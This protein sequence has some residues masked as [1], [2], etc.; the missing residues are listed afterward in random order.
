MT[1]L[2]ERIKVGAKAAVKDSAEEGRPTFSASQADGFQLWWRVLSL[3]GVSPYEAV[4]A[5]SCLA[6]S[7]RLWVSS[8]KTS[9]AGGPFEATC[10]WASLARAQ[11]YRWKI[12]NTANEKN[13]WVSDIRWCFFVVVFFAASEGSC[14]ILM[15]EWPNR[16][17]ADPPLL[18]HGVPVL[19]VSADAWPSPHSW[20]TVADKMSFYW[21]CN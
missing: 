6:A 10:Y 13:I 9:S 3:T 4:E 1:H 12:K 21:V 20:Q 17:S 2:H 14:W 8:E 7:L 16:L 5:T 15:I 11:E 19:W 18:W